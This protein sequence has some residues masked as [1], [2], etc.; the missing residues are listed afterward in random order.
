MNMKTVK[1][2]LTRPV[3]YAAKRMIGLD[4]GSRFI[5]LVE[6]EGTLGGYSLKKIGIRE[7][8]LDVIVD[9]EV[10]D[11][12]TLVDVIGS[13]VRE[14]ETEEKS[15]ALTVSGRD[16]LVK[17]VETELRERELSRRR[18][19]IAR[20][21]IPYDIEDVCFDIMPL[22][23]I[24]NKVVVAAAKNEKIYSLLGIV[25]EAG[26]TPVT[27]TTVPIVIEELSRTNE[28]V[29]K[30]GIY[31][32][33]SIGDDRT[34]V[35]LIKDGVL[36]KYIDV[37]IGVDTYLKDIARDHAIP[38]DEA[39]PILLGEEAITKGVTKTINTDTRSIIKQTTGFLKTEDVECKGIILTGEGATIPGLKDSFESAVGVDCK[40]GNPFERITTEETVDL[41]NRFDIATGLAITGLK[42]AGVNLLPL[43][44]RPVKE[45]RVAAALM[46]GFPLWAGGIV[47]V[48]FVLLYISVGFRIQDTKASIETL[49]VQEKSVM[50]RVALL[51]DLKNKGKEATKRIEIV[52]D[53]EE[54]KFSRVKLMDEINRIIPPYTWLTF[55]NE[56]GGNE[57]GFGVL[58]KG[59]TESN[60]AV[61][62]F[63]KR[64][65]SSSHF[66][67]VELSYTKMSEIRG[68]EVTEFEIRAN[69]QE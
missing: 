48:A 54:G 5:K 64:L 56:V 9:G 31:M 32:V 68:V 43:E 18:E 67:G 8:P 30:E 2:V 23:G 47:I 12:D 42:K 34:D 51:E 60:L 28:L 53:L 7:L 15:V 69:F 10:M 58:I 39:V 35:V 41:P 24:P 3:F 62:E 13:F 66:S 11:T 61:S 50:E 22:K 14:Y 19:D 36:E 52:Q 49:K 20:T 21:N 33:V 37:R 4:I 17:P 57:R 40:I 46:G 26:L 1:E 55:L 45:K 59:V 29:P 6:I 44:L 25:Q 38:V 65:E 63:L 27:I 16:V